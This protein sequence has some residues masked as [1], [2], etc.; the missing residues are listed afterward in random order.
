MN[1]E[2][3]LKIVYNEVLELNKYQQQG[4]DL[5][6][7]KLNWILV[8]DSV[9]LAAFYNLKEYNLVVVFLVS[10]SIV[11]SVVGFSPIRMKVTAKITSQLEKIDQDDFLEYLVAKKR[12]AYIG[13][14]SRSKNLENILWIAQ[15]SLAGAISLQ[16][17]LIFSRI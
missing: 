6:F 8:A 5:M 7:N 17:L 9:I 11:F 1:K 14:A 3:N 13:N 15:W 12:E 4:I 10:L 2:E 16:F